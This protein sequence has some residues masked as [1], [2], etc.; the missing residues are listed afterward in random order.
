M[1]YL[2]KNVFQ[3]AGMESIRDDSVHA[4]IPNRSRGYRLTE[5]GTLLNCNLADTS[6]KIPGGGM[7][8]TSIDLVKFALA[9]R[10]GELLK[11]KSVER[12]FTAQTLADGKKTRYGLGWNVEVSDGEKWVAH[13]GGQQGTSTILI[14]LP[15]K[16][17]V[18]AAMANLERA[19]VQKIAVG[20]VRALRE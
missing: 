17:I 10:N 6:N 2:E 12:M 16:G 14:M 19:P 5:D 4:I 1:D 3:P 7:V 15:D 8:S 9:V 20:I 18:A 13:S 11:P